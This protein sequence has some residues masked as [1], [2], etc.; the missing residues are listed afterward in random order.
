MGFGVLRASGFGR[1]RVL[2]FCLVLRFWTDVVQVDGR[3]SL[4]KAL[5][6]VVFACQD[7]APKQVFNRT[8]TFMREHLGRN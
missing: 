1:S 2:R 3:H 5:L 7:C 8:L 4:A 6:S